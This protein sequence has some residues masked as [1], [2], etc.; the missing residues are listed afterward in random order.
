VTDHWGQPFA[1]FKVE[2]VPAGERRLA[3]MRV[4]SRL[5][6]TEYVVFPEKVGPLAEIPLDLKPYL[7][8]GFKYDITNPVIREAVGTAVGTENRPYWMMRRIFN[9]ILAKIDYK[10]KPLGGWNPAPTVLERGTGSCSE[11][12]FVFIAMCRA[13]GLPARYVGSVVVRDGD[14]GR[15]E[16]WHRWPEVYLPRYGWIPV[17][18]SAEGKRD[19]TGGI[20][21]LI[22]T[23]GNRYL[24]TTEGGGD[25]EYLDTYYNFKVSWQT[26]GKCRVENR[27]WGEYTPVAENPAR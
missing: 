12:S 26:R 14:R 13:A 17:D 8:D 22:G 24:I 16:V 27:T 11:Y 9:Y 2:S 6:H 25:S 21:R 1:R 7:A 23:V 3:L 10:L 5:Y 19:T 20:A 18:P 4:R 15:D